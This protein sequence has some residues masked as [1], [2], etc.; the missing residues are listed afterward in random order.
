[1]NIGSLG[2][3]RTDFLPADKE[4]IIVTMETLENEIKHGKKCCKRIVTC[5]LM[6]CV[7]LIDSNTHS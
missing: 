7:G 2:G 6:A 3:M 5:F 1:M 4:Q